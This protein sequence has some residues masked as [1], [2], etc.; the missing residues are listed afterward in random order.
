MNHPS[1]EQLGLTLGLKR[2]RAPAI[3][4]TTA[5]EDDR[6]E[7]ALEEGIQVSSLAR[8]QE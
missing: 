7:I 2:T 3:P 8:R 6:M 4:F 1:A 5:A